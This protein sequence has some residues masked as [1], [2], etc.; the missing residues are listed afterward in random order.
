MPRRKMV[1]STNT[2]Y[3]VFNKSRTEETIFI[4]EKDYER[5]YLNLVR[6]DYEFKQKY[7]LTVK[8][9][10]LMPNH[11]HLLLYLGDP[12]VDDYQWIIPNF[13][14]KLQSSYAKY[15]NIKYSTP[16]SLRK[17]RYKIKPIT[18]DAYMWAIVNYIQKNSEK[19]LKIPYEKWKRRSDINTKETFEKMIDSLEE[20]D[21]ER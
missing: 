16:G 5:F 17:D 12:G 19:H 14:M 13:M 20:I 18:N 10:C 4:Q 3:H 11:F 8:A 2:Y 9:R 7:N 1:F 6:Y 15:F 21:L